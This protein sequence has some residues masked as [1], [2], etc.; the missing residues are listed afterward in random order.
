MGDLPMAPDIELPWPISIA[1]FLMCV[2]VSI[3]ISRWFYN[4]PT[5]GT[6][7]EQPDTETE[8]SDS[9]QPD[10]AAEIS[11]TRGER[12]HDRAVRRAEFLFLGLCHWFM[13]HCRQFH[14]AW[15]QA[16]S[17]LDIHLSKSEVTPIRRKSRCCVL[18]A[19]ILAG[20][21]GLLQL[22]PN[23]IAALGLD[24]YYEG[25][26]TSYDAYMK[27]LLNVVFGSA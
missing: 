8:I 16:A 2:G 13:T 17:L 3:K 1:L 21:A 4:E 9:E 11:D 7:G 26:G 15:N 12:S 10:T 20:S 22:L 24:P 18:C 14:D 6:D 19:A 23:Y 25:C 27:L 5:T